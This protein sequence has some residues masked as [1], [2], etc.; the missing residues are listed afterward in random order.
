MREL[1]G[2]GTV[3]IL[4]FFQSS[5]RNLFVQLLSFLFYV[6]PT[7]SNPSEQSFPTISHFSSLKFSFFKFSLYKR[8]QKYKGII[9]YASVLSQCNF[10]AS[11]LMNKEEV[12]CSYKRRMHFRNEFQIKF[13]Y[14]F[15]Q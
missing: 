5:E 13:V 7:V 14:I 6:L 4:L 2:K 9:G 15:L 1:G 3:A 8:V 11:D 10:S 12:T